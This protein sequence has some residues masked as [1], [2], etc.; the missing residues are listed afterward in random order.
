MPEVPSQ[1]IESMSFRADRRVRLLRLLAVAAAFA[2]LLIA[3]LL[4]AERV[5][6]GMAGGA[7]LT[8][9][10]ASQQL[11]HAGA[12]LRQS[13]H[14]AW[15]SEQRLRLIFDAFPN[16]VVVS[17]LA[18]GRYLE[19]NPAA[20]KRLNRTREQL[21]GSTMSELGVVVSEADRL[22]QVRALELSGRVD[23]AQSR[24]QMPDGRVFWS[25][26][27]ARLIELDGVKSAI[28]VTTDI[29][30][31]KQ[32]EEQLR[33]S[34]RSF[35]ELFESAPVPMSY[36]VLG[37][38]E[39]PE[40]S[41]WNR[42]WF[43]TFGYE[44]EAV[45]GLPGFSFGFWVDESQR[46]SILKRAARQTQVQSEEVLL[47][48]ADGTVRTVVVS[49]RGIE[50]LGARQLLVSYQ[51][52]TQQRQAALRLGELAEMV[53]SAHDGM[54][55]MGDGVITEC[56]EAAGRIFGRPRED[57]LGRAPAELSPELQ[58]DGR[59]SA[60]LSQA[61]MD[62]ACEGRAQRFVWRH[63]RA[64]GSSFMADVV[65]NAARGLEPS[66]GGRRFIAVV[67]D[68]TESLQAAQALAASEQR[69]RQLFEHSPV[70]LALAAPDGRIVTVNRVWTS[71]LGYSAQEVQFID[72]WWQLAYPD[73][74]YRAQSQQ[75]WASELERVQREGGEPE[76]AEYVV[77]CKNG[78][79]RHVLIGAAW[80]GGDLLAS[81]HD[82]TEQRQA[83]AQLEA[84]NAGLESRVKERTRELSEALEGLKQAQDDLVRSEKLAGLGALVAGVSHELNTPIG[85]AVMVASTQ[86]E[87]LRRF[88]K[89][90][91]TGL[92][93]SQLTAFLGDALE[94]AEV[95][96]RNLQRAAEL[97]NSFKQVAVDQSSYQRRGFAV[98]DLLHELSL[99]LSPT[100]RRQHVTLV[101]E[102][103][104]G[105]FMDSYPGPLTQVLIN[106]VNNA[107][108]HAFD[109]MPEGR[110]VR[111]VAAAS[112]PERLRIE[113]E[114]NG[115]G[116]A[117]EHLP[118]VFDPFFTTKLG[119]G[120]SGLGLHIVYSLVT[121]LLGGAVRIA[122]STAQG[123]RVTLELPTIAP[124]ATAGAQKETA[125]E[126]Q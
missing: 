72:Q 13:A 122:S 17:T 74:V 9:L 38:D 47:R 125:S 59:Q 54:L 123:T 12:A 50:R 97:V 89:E 39:L 32:A 86:L 91:E 10:F 88:E 102:V 95:V 48:H 98:E 16:P 119:R 60:V 1:A 96:E 7:C 84:L 93:R 4:P 76:A 14:R 78:D 121:E 21:I 18:E 107:V 58:D 120:G 108:A 22:S 11:G 56:N 55:L 64:D 126:Q 99:M 83:Q 69:F 25:L 15:R 118:R 100:L 33:L 5:L 30:S 41:Y 65:L 62:A 80:I 3:W 112:S 31:L 110:R 113:V 46:R 27:S 67:R 52:M 82:V 28:A 115:A 105:L 53:E 29:T 116:I 45:N 36:S 44:P 26:Y 8:L 87:R 43:D 75:R 66:S 81:F 37:A 94:S 117:A 6:L 61:Y 68:I 106:L 111:I 19:V 109:A 77:R 124:V 40:A 90:T 42:A 51:D 34:E 73:P 70:A 57:L 101:E 2:G 85:N 103:S 114:D 92:R 63:L 20:A 79:S 49:V 104:P 24:V 71:L 23:G 35:E